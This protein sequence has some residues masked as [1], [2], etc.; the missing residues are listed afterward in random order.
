M[1]DGSVYEDFRK[2][3]TVITNTEK[4]ACQKCLD[5]LSALENDVGQVNIKYNLL[6]LL[7]FVFNLTGS[8]FYAFI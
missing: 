7:F 8:L 4:K 2:Y 5:N 3:F 6:L 1:Q